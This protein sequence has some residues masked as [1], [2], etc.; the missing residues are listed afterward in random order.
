MK[1]NYEI[2]VALIKPLIIRFIRFVGVGVFCVAFNWTANYVLLVHY[3]T[4]LR[5]TYIVVYLFSIMLSFLLNSH[6]T[7][8]SKKTLKNLI[9][10]FI[11]Y[12]SAMIIGIF[13]LE[14]YEYL[15]DFE[16]WVY[17]MMVTPITML[18]NFFNASRVL[19]PHYR[20]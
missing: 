16:K 17:P 8:E 3:D 14:I 20:K 12:L 6:F 7:Y 4:Q 5:P 1:I 19:N 11:I 18:W 9:S 10:Y 13:L 15:F 2:R